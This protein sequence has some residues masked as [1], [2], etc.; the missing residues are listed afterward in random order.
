MTCDRP[1]ASR[2]RQRGAAAVF[3]AV[4]LVAGLAAAALA[5]DIGRLYY[6]QRDLQRVANMAALDAARVAGGCYGQPTNAEAVA[7]AE[8]LGSIGRNGGRRSDI[9]PQRVEVGQRVRGADG[10]RRFVSI[11]D[12]RN[13]AVRV[14]LR[15]PAPSR[16]MQV[17]RREGEPPMLAAAASAHSRPAAWVEV[18][19]R[20]VQLRPDILDDFFKQ[21]FGETPRLDLVSYQNLFGADVPIA[22][23]LDEIGIGSPDE[24]FEFELPPRDLLRALVAVLGDTGNRAA[25]SAAEQLAAVAVLPSTVTPAEVLAIERG[26]FESLGNATIGAG[27][28]VLA[29]AQAANGSALFDLPLSLPPPLGGGGGRFR[30]IVPGRPAELTPGT[31]ASAGTET[32]AA[33]GQAVL[34]ANLNVTLPYVGAIVLPLYVEGAQAT[35]TIDQIECARR[36]DPVDRVVVHARSSISRL[37]IG[38]FDDIQLPRPVA[39]PATLVDISNARIPVLGVLGGEIPVPVRIRIDAYSSVDIPSEAAD[40]PFESPFPRT[41]SIGRPQATALARAISEVPA[42]LAIDVRIDVLNN[43]LPLVPGVLNATLETARQAIRAALLNQ[44]S[45]ALTVFADG[46][47]DPMFQN[48]GLSIGGAD[49]TV[50]SVVADQPELFER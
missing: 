42:N 48:L 24:V 6:A 50:R 17:S 12:E 30:F 14:V 11:P 19:S 41:D 1:R 26:T 10:N 28:L 3:A 4:G 36:G 34:E 38:R 45:G 9:T 22:G 13:R 43:N 33:N 35:A 25:Q 18:G 37:G 23:L 20:L 15:R 27:S 5:I 29:L 46:V 16:L 21:A 40:L 31:P 44:I 39:R 49:V 47:L 2:A 32:F 8:V 7:L